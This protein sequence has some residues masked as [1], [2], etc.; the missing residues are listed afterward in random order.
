MV[1]AARDL[2]RA[3]VLAGQVAHTPA[4]DE[5]SR[6]A[7]AEWDLILDDGRR[8]N[9]ARCIYGDL[10]TWLTKIRDEDANALVSTPPYHTQHD[11]PPNPRQRTT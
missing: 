10:L 1:S 7:A 11:A 5:R 8:A 9:F 2:V 6:L 3:R 4:L